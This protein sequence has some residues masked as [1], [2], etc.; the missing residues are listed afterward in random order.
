[1]NIWKMYDVAQDQ[2]K[3]RKVQYCPEWKWLQESVP[4]PAKCP[5]FG[6]TSRF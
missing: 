1:M 2:Y 6:G 4:I 3:N 5:D